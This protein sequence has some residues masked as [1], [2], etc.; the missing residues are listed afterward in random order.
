[1]SMSSAVGLILALLLNAYANAGPF[2]STER[3]L[4][5]YDKLG[6]FTVPL[7]ASPHSVK[8]KV[9]DFIWQHWQQH[10]RGYAVVTFHSIEGEPSTSHMFI[11]PNRDGV[12]HLSVRIERKLI[13][14]RGWSNPELR[15]KLIPQTNSYE[16]FAIERLMD[17]NSYRL[18]F[19]DKDGTVMRDW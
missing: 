6:P 10:R 3:N 11:E 19:R 9:R 16:V 15:G 12:W 1:M 14:R 17:G 8:G 4:S 18:R 7:G 13:D 5:R 2:E